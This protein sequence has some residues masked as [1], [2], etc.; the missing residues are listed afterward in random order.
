MQLQSLEALLHPLPIL[1]VLLFGQ[2]AYM[3][4]FLRIA[5]EH[6]RADQ[7]GGVAHGMHQR[8]RIVDDEPPRGDA[9]FQPRHEVLAGWLCRRGREGR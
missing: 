6:A 3:R 9:M 5:L 2:F 8:F 4:V 7:V 1:Q